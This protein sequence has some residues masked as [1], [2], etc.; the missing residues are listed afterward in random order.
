MTGTLFA[1]AILLGTLA[2]ILFAFNLAIELVRF[3]CDVGFSLHEPTRADAWHAF[4]NTALEIA[5]FTGLFYAL[6][7]AIRLIGGTM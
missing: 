5:V 3:T 2:A 6:L 7:R 4:T 1:Q